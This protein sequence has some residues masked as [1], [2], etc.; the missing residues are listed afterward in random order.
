MDKAPAYEDRRIELEERLNE[1]KKQNMDYEVARQMEEPMVHELLAQVNKLK[2]SVQDYNKQQ[3]NM[4][5]Q[6]KELNEKLDAI[7]G[8]ISQLDFEL[9]KKAEENSEL[10]SKVVQSP[11]RLQRALEEKRKKLAEVKNPEMASIQYVQEKNAALEMYTKAFGK[12]SK[13]SS[14]EH[15]LLEQFR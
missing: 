7:D 15:A 11:E 12:L 5:N 14:Q 9:L 3:M 2:Q 6:D 13:L 4:R 8:K 10:L 1:L